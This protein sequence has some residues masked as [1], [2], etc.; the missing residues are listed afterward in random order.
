VKELKKYLPLDTPIVIA[1]NKCDLP[2]RMI[3]I[4]RA[5]AYDT[6]LDLIL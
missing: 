1:G 3:P 2:N 4:E 5:E 6:C